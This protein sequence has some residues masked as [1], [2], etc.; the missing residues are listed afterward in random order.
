LGTTHQILGHR[1]F[2]CRAHKGFFLREQFK[3][4]TPPTKNEEGNPQRPEPGT[5]V[6]VKKPLL[7][8]GGT[9]N[10]LRP[11][12]IENPRGAQKGLR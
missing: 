9:S 6:P 11:P 3:V 4:T 7:E 10:N 2:F 12:R 5:V 8:S 1:A